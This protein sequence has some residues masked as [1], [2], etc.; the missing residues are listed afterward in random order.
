MNQT[1][2]QAE[3][4]SDTATRSAHSC[5]EKRYF[6]Y[7]IRRYNKRLYRIGMSYFK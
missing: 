1:I 3:S 4:M 5:W 7:I 6:E 2:F